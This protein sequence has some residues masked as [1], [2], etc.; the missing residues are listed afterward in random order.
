VVTLVDDEHAELARVKASEASTTKAL[1]GAD[2]D[3][4][5]PGALVGLLDRGAK[6]EVGE[7]VARLLEQLAAVSDD[8]STLASR[9][10]APRDLGEADG[11]AC[12]GRK[13]E[14]SAAI[15]TCPLCLDSRDRL[16]L[17]RAQGGGITRAEISARCRPLVLNGGPRPRAPSEVSQAAR[18]SR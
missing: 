2:D 4:R 11:L 1:H 9:D 12:T 15:A 14:Q 18:P 13:L 7:L 3:G 17:V 8:E 10:D 5:L 6:A 16:L